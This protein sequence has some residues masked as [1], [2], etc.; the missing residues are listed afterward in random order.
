MYNELERL[1]IENSYKK[2]K[3]IKIL[4]IGDKNTGKT[5]FLDQYCYNQI[6]KLNKKSKNLEGC[7]IH[8]K[9]YPFFQNFESFTINE[10]FILEFWDVLGDK[11][12]RPFIN[13]YLEKILPH[14]KAIIFFFDLSNIKTLGNINI[15]IQNLFEIKKTSNLNYSIWKIPFF[16]IGNKKDL[17]T[18]K[19]LLEEKIKVLN[20]LNQKFNCV[21]GENVLFFSTKFEN[22]NFLENLLID[23][24]FRQICLETIVFH[25]QED[26]INSESISYFIP[27][28]NTKSTVKYTLESEFFIN[29]LQLQK[30][31]KENLKNIFIDFLTVYSKKIKKF[32]TYEEE[33]YF[34]DLKKGSY[35]IK[36]VSDSSLT[37]SL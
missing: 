13:I 34:L 2:S 11:L 6:G 23:H 25:K 7:E 3:K 14:S 20:F 32:F 26:F 5:T 36:E 8:V 12:Y 19:Q 28:F 9:N 22:E 18:N 17:L 1:K 35:S 24:F 15:W 29:K 4:V 37:Q 27:H 33:K 21:E 31:D 10:N 30:I 16:L